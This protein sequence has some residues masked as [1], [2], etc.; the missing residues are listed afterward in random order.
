MDSIE[1]KVASYS[2]LVVWYPISLTMKDPSME[3]IFEKCPKDET[4]HKSENSFL[5]SGQSMRNIPSGDW[6]SNHGGHEPGASSDPLESGIVEQLDISPWVDE[7]LGLFAIV[8]VI[9]ESP[10]GEHHLPP[11]TL[12]Q[13]EFVLL[14]QSGA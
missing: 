12:A 11:V 14:S 8:D 2:I 6:E 7:H 1:H 10:L 3:H 13:V 4:S 5:K 9:L